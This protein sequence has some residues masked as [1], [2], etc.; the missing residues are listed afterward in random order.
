MYSLLITSC[1]HDY[2]PKKAQIYQI[3]L[4]DH[5]LK[6]N[7]HAEDVTVHFFDF[8]SSIIQYVAFYVARFCF[9]SHINLKTQ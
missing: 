8:L 6:D 2:N 7:R 1:K 5:Y 3:Y 4:Y 9:I